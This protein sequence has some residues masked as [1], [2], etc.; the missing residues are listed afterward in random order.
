MTTIRPNVFPSAITS[1]LFGNITIEVTPNQLYTA[2]SEVLKTV[3]TL[4][5][6]FDSL[7]S[8]VKG[9][10]NYWEGNVS[11]RRQMTHAK[12]EQQMEEMLKILTQY[13]QELKQIASN[14]ADTE[15]QNTEASASLPS[16]IL[17]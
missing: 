12:S 16:G 11:D 5:G 13:A 3:S 2:S 10:K 4:R 1:A 8:R 17:T 6:R 14:Y 7:N 9:M 15:S